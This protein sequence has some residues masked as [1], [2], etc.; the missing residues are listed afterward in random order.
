[1]SNGV[2]TGQGAEFIVKLDGVGLTDDQKATIAKEIQGITL[3]ELA[4][5]DLSD[6]LAIRIPR[7]TWLGIWIDTFD[8]GAV[9]RFAVTRHE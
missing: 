9:P 5:V 3:R 2:N 7:R 1:M 4:K 6:D 8:R